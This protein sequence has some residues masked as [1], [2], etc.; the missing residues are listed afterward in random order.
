MLLV[1]R[2]SPCGQRRLGGREQV[3]DLPVGERF[4][5]ALADADADLPL[6]TAQEPLLAGAGGVVQPPDGVHGLPEQVHQR[7]DTVQL[8]GQLGSGGDALRACQL[9]TRAV[10]G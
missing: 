1:A 4:G 2:A 3:G 8:L 10:L 6:L 9:S 5:A 7:L